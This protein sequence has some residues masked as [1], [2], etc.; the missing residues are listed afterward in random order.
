[1]TKILKIETF[2]KTNNNKINTK[3]ITNILNV[4]NNNLIKDQIY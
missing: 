2:F 1:M 4:R 3:E